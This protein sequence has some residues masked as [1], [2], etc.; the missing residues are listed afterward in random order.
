MKHPLSQKCRN[1]AIQ[2]IPWVRSLG[3]N[4]T[5]VGPDGCGK[6]V[7][8]EYCFSRLSGA[9]VS[10]ATSRSVILIADSSC[11]SSCCSS[12]FF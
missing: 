9:Q 3:G 12:A 7:L 5:Q 4:V 8:L 11:G 6:S 10:R 2:L 1:D